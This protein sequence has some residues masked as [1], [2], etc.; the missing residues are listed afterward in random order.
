M[1]YLIA[2]LLSVLCS[3]WI[4]GREM[5]INPDAICYLQ[6]AASMKDGIH[7]A[8]NLCGQ[9]KWPFYSLLIAGFVHVTHFSYENSAYLLNGFFSL[10]T[11]LVFMRIVAFLADKTVL[12][13]NK[14]LLISLGAAVILLAHE[15]NAVKTYIIRDHGFWAFYLTSLLCLLYYFRGRQWYY[16]LAWSMS[17]VV[18]TLFR[19]EGAIFLL[20]MPWIAWFETNQNKTARLKAFLALNSFTIAAVIL[21]CGLFLLYHPQLTARLSELQFQ[22]LH[23]L[24]VLKQNF[25]L[26]ALGLTQAVLGE[27]SARDATPV[28]FIT[29]IVWYFFNVIS[30]LSFIYSLLVCYAWFRKLL[31]ANQITRLI[32]WSYVVVNVLITAVF[33]GQSMFLSK[34]YII[35]LSL[36]LMLWIPFALLSLIQQWRR[37]KWPLLL[38]IL[39]IFISSL[40]GLFNFGYSKTYIHDAGQWLSQNVPANATLYSNDLQVMY[41]SN[42]FGNQ[43]FAQFQANSDPQGLTD[44]QWKKY[45]YLAIRLDQNALYQLSPPSSLRAKRSNPSRKQ[46]LVPKIIFLKPCFRDGLL[47]FARNDDGGLS[48]KTFNSATDNLTD[49]NLILIQVFQNKRGDQVRIYRRFS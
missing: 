31:I 13:K 35:A 29:L 9:A 20:V 32:L 44:R 40:G 14:S 7:V 45:D 26:K 19:I 24:V 22:L 11:V 33:L 15:F 30:N 3:F 1:L 18:A 16:A 10:L 28:L 47:R 46:S 36:V 34:R 37:R 49:I 38:A 21:G 48:C 43:I 41:Y 5:V 4:S 25:Q 23:G 27:S 8:M 17:I 39:F 12:E 6:S 2:A 42:H